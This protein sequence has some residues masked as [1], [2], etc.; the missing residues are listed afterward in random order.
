VGNTREAEGTTRL[1]YEAKLVSGEGSHPKNRE[2]TVDIGNIIKE[3]S[4]SRLHKLLRVTA[5]L[6]R[7]TD[8]LRKQATTTGPLTASELERARLMWDLYV[9][10]RSYSVVIQSVRQGKKSDLGDKLTQFGNGLLRC[11]GNTVM[12]A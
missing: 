8:K 12:L 2:K 10:N 3:E 9:Q 5:W 11:K 6:L 7:F 4:I 1:F